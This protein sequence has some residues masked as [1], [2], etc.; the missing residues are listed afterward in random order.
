MDDDSR[1]TDSGKMMEARPPSLPPEPPRS[2]KGQATKQRILDA[3]VALFAVRAYDDVQVFEIAEGAGV[4]HGL[5]FHHFGTKRGLY[6]E[7]VREIS[8]RIFE[9]PQRGSTLS[10][11]DLTRKILREHFGH[12]AENEPLM[13]A[14]TRGLSVMQ[15]D[16]EAWAVLE[17]DRIELTK[18]ALELFGYDPQSAVL[19][20]T[21]TLAG[22]AMDGLGVR[23]LQEGRTWDIDTELVEATIELFVGAFRAAARLDP[24]LDVE[25]GIARLQNR[26]V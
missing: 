19:R 4:A 20:T 15:S 6:L 2:R 10:T 13:I 17:A 11:Y 5:M 18:Y 16:P 24:T 7:A 9:R 8:R 23:W 3:A 14:Y 21:L 22:L 1:V 26:P 12:I 25:P